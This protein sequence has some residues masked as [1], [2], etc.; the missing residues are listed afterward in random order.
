MFVDEASQLLLPVTPY[1]VLL[2][3]LATV[4]AFRHRAT[5]LGRW[6]WGV[7]AALLWSG[8][9]SSPE[10]GNRII[11]SIEA[12][13]PPLPPVA[14]PP[15][16]NKP[17]IVVLTTGSIFKDGDGYRVELE[18]SGWERAHGAVELWRRIGGELL[19][20]GGP[21]RDGK[22]SVAAHMA[23][24]ARSW[25]VPAA[26]VRVEER[27][28]TTYE[29]LAFTRDVIAAHDGDT[30]LVTSAIHMRRALAVASKL[31]LRVRAYPCD[32]KWRPMSH[33][34]AWLP[35]AGGPDL[36]AQALHEII[37]LRVYRMR[38]FAD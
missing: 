33:W 10:L 3:L 26:A 14:A 18:G 24:L 7:L 28:R 20:V 16:S 22:A 29:N 17:L 11:G 32:H 9:M 4:W 37:G 35:N 15:A 6:R 21:S 25:G 34:Y 27:S 13:Y 19:F 31:G 5:R 2:L 8:C 36:F 1:L 23:A 12:D 30:W 38:G